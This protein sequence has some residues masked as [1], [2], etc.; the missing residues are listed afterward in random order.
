MK[1]ISIIYFTGSGST[2]KFAEAVARGAASVSGADVKLVA[3]DS[4]DIVNGRYT[5]NQVIDDLDESSAIIF[6]TPTY[7]GGCAAQFKAFADATVASWYQQKWRNKIA[8]GFTV[9]GTPSGD[10]LSTLQ[11]LQTL[12]MQ[13]GMIWIGSGELPM[14][15]NG[16]NRLGTWLGG[17][18]QSVHDDTN[19]IHAEDLRSGELFGE[20]VAAFTI[21]NN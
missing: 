21:G 7:M 14:Q 18:A 1:R 9:S 15:P 2:A 17:M 12:A 8:A 3:I 20:R 19:L 5:N 13:H 11:Y 6:G 10:K 16:I 4:A